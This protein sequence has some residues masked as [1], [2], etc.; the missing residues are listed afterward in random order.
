MNRMLVLSALT[1]RGGFGRQVYRRFAGSL[2]ATG[3]AGDVVILTTAEEMLSRRIW[4]LHDEIDCLVFSTIP[5]P[6]DDRDINCYRYQHFREYLSPRA[7]DY[8]YVMLS[9]ARDVVFQRNISQFPFQPGT[10][11]FLAEEEK[12]IGEC[13]INSGWILDLYGEDCLEALKNRTVLCSGTTIGRTPAML[14]YLQLMIEQIDRADARFHERF[15]FLGGIDQGM[16][17][18]LYHTDKFGGL[19]VRTCHNR[20]GL[21][22]T[23]GHVAGDDPERAFLDDRARFVNQDGEL[24][25]CVHQFDRLG[26][27]V[28]EA[29][30]RQNPYPI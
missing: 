8:D 4:T 14:Q 19:N 28:R 10:D 20:E 5:R 26:P 16:H 15:G 29:F 1:G 23:V 11:L 12:R 27:Q 13:G 2:A 30:N 25:Y 17:N 21:I 3:F 6:G 7:E 18:Y 24:C 22:Y 9:D